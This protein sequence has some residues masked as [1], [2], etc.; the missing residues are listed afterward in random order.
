MKNK[1]A[2][3][4]DLFHPLHVKFLRSIDC[5]FIPLSEKIPKNYDIYIV[6]GTYIKPILMRKLGKIGKNKKIVTLFSD[7]RLFYLSIG[8]KFDFKKEK[9]VKS[10]K[11]R[12]I[13]AKK[14]IKKLD[15]AI[16]TSS[17]TASLFRK[18]NKKAPFIVTPGFVFRENKDSIEKIRP[19]LKNHNILFIGHGPDFYCKGLDLLI[20]SFKEIKKDFPRANLYILGEWKIK[21]AWAIK[22]IHFEGKQNL[23]PYLKKCSLGVH[24]GRGEAFGINILETMLAGI[25]TMVSEYT[26]TRD[27]VEKADRKL[28]VPLKKSIIIRTIS[29]YFKSN[30]KY[31][32][33]LSK[34]CKKISREFNE[35]DMLKNFKGKFPKFIENIERLKS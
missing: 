17:L 8:K 5:D 3:V 9:I 14:L 11:W 25:P 20:D 29:D 16:F 4:Y 6:E 35:E 2:F 32:K 13:A 7:P 15:G 19:N 28:I 23:I 33:E 10:P 31:K 18:F 24:L 34:K 1:I 12:L 22:G 30:L 26:G 21:K 27:M